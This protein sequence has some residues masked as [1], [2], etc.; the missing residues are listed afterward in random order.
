MAVAIG[1]REERIRYQASQFNVTGLPNRL[2]LCERMNADLAAPA[3]PRSAALMLGL[4]GLQ[5]IIN[6]LGRAFGDHLMRHVGARTRSGGRRRR[7]GR[8]G[9]RHRLRRLDIRRH[10]ADGHGAPVVGGC[11]W[12]FQGR[13]SYGGCRHRHRH[14]LCPA[15]MATMADLL[16]RRAE[17]AL[18]AGPDLA[19]ERVVIYDPATRSPQLRP[20]VADERSAPGDRIRSSVCITSPKIDLTPALIAGAEAL[21]RWTHP[22]VA[23][24]RLTSSSSWPRIPATFVRLTNWAL[25][26]EIAQAARWRPTRN[27]PA[28]FGQSFGARSGRPGQSGRVAVELETPW[29][30]AVL[31][32]RLGDHRKCHHGRAR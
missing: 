31:E 32:H 6:T 22:S 21:V 12:L 29:G 8:P 4:A 16:L 1:E 9:Q 25:G 5:E 28:H 11:R 15:D 26:T 10:S 17:T 7:Y 13:R 27:E 30:A 20:V 2:A 3:G 19:D 24:C 14:R 18:H 23:L